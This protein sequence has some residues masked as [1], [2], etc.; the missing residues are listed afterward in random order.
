MNRN[1]RKTHDKPILWA[2]R[3]SLYSGKA[4]SYLIKKGIEYREISNSNPR[5]MEEVVPLIG[6][7]AIPVTELPDGTLIQDTTDTILHF[8]A[9]VAAP[10]LIPTS[11]LQHT[12][13]WILGCFGSESMWKL[14]LHYR[15]TY[16]EEQRPFI[17]ALFGRSVSS[18]KSAAER[19][20]AA[21]PVMAKFGGKLRELGVTKETIPSMEASYEELL[22]LLN[23]HFFQYPYLMGG[24][25]SLADFGLIAPFYAHLA[26]DP[27]PSNHMKNRAPNVFRWTERMFEQGFFD[28][29]FSELAPE[30]LPNDALP[31]S[32]IPILA[33]FFR[34][35]SA[36][37]IAMVESYDNWGAT[38]A[39]DASG[40]RIQDPQEPGT[41]HP[42]LGWIEFECRGVRHRRRDSIDIVYHLQRVFDVVDQLEGT[43]RQAYEALLKE[44]GGEAL[45]AVRPARRIDYDCY[46]YV[47]A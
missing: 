23:E 11:P 37:F 19:L 9:T 7:V 35:F 15:W 18:A 14:G 16:L 6:H 25:P 26:R 41:T 44:T 34:D 45:M 22:D 10:A 39:N 1:T 32:L 24:R 2:A 8:E 5:F 12:V 13:A 3:G 42:S 47:L 28:G 33:Y 27:Y 20:Q 30:F 40:A 38:Q 17:E 29:E 4:R 46:H 36:E 31:E 21:A 43:A